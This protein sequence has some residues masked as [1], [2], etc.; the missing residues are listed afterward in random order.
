MPRKSINFYG[1]DKE[2]FDACGKLICR[3]NRRHMEIVNVWFLVLNVLLSLF[4]CFE[5]FAV[6]KRYLRVYILY[7]CIAVGL[8]I[9]IRFAP[10]AIDA[11]GRLMIV[12]Y[13]AILV[14]YGICSSVAQPYMASAMFPVLIVVIGI[15]FI[16]TLSL[17]TGVLML[18][19]IVFLFFS[20]REK[21][22]AVAYQDLYHTI[23]YFA[24]ALALHYT[25]QHIRMRQF[26]TTLK[27]IQIQRELE[28]K[29]SF[30]S[31][32]SLLNRGRFFSLASEVLHSSNR[33]Y[34]ALCL[35]NLTEFSEINDKLGHQMGDKTLQITGSTVLHAIGSDTSEKWSLPERIIREKK[36]FAG[37][38]D[39][40]EFVFLL[41]AFSEREQLVSILQN[42]LLTLNQVNF[43][44]LH[45]ISASIGVVEID[46]S[47]KD[48]DHVYHLAK[49]A[50]AASKVAGT[51]QIAFSS[52]TT[53]GNA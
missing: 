8:E 26:E 42:M 11:M 28:V 2:T 7:L 31:L 6:N 13:I 16:D 18:S 15:S 3:T 37:R 17:M 21:A 48:I 19:C 45:G 50:L 22:Y 30:D 34:L 49:E 35:M 27:N 44:D 40:D 20:F 43:G 53:G 36:S 4:A 47:E 51:N 14:S 23:I 1:Y 29:S 9:L 32:T 41:R 25:F 10:K 5:I 38:I 12:I 24:L 39:G 52:Q 46:N 33:E